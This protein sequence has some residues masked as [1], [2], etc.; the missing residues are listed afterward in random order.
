MKMNA[1]QAPKRVMQ[2]PTRRES[3]EGRCQWEKTSEQAHWFCRGIGGGMQTKGTSRNTGSP[4]GGC[5]RDQP[6]TR[7]SQTGPCGV[8]ER[9]VVPRKPGNAGGGKGPQLKGDATSDE[10]PRDWR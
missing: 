8:A 10:G 5:S 7:E 4:S 1:E 3:R 2:E 9:P 6:E